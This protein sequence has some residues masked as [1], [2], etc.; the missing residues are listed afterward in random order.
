MSKSLT[1]TAR[2]YGGSASTG[3]LSPLHSRRWRAP[4]RARN[5]DSDAGPPCGNADDRISQMTGFPAAVDVAVVGAGAAGIGALRRLVEVGGVSVLGVEARSRVGGR[6][7]TIAPAGF[8]L[9]RGAEWLHL[10]DRNP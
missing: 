4:L 2:A 8:A 9:D 10:A 7:N 5:S 3:I 1:V 6:I